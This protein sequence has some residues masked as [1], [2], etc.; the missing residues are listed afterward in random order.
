MRQHGDKIMFTIN[1]IKPQKSKN[2]GEEIMAMFNHAC[3]LAF[4]FESNHPQG[5]DI[6][7]EQFT[8]AVIKRIAEIIDYG[9]AECKDA[10]LPPYD[11]YSI[12]E[13]S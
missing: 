2:A 9:V 4:T 8:A 3:T 6:T 12:L 11:T 10:I 1:D 5:E 13:E 7:L